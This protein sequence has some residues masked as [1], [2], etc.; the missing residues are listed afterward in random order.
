MGL[1]ACGMIDSDRAPEI[2]FDDPK[3]V[4]LVKAL[5]RGNVDDVDRLV[6]EG[7]DVD[8]VG[9]DGV[10]PL[11][12]LMAMEKYPNKV[13]FQH[14]VDLEANPL[15]FHTLSG[16]T[17][18]LIS[19]RHPDPDYLTI[20]LK[21]GVDPNFKHPGEPSLP[22]ALYHAI[23]TRNFEH[24]QILLDYDADTE[25]RNSVGE[26]PLHTTKTNNWQAAYILLENG[27]DYTAATEF[28]GHT[29]I[30]W[31]ENNRY[32]SPDDGSTDWREKVVK[33]LRER[34]VEVKPWM[35]PDE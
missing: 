32:W 23:F 17:A 15:G 16:R 6:A 27:A 30:T 10:T 25:L 9:K 11:Y 18:F 35:P 7:V 31:L 1:T 2:F 13:G 14:L 5:A 26:T 33:F 3:V 19:A 28:G 21:S 12:W 20:L 8:S 34:G 24:M 4:S 22:T 29:I